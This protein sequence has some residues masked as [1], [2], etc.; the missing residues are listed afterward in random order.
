MT[1]WSHGRP[2]FGRMKSTMQKRRAEVGTLLL[3]F[4]VCARKTVLSKPPHPSPAQ[5]WASLDPLL[6]PA[7][8][9]AGFQLGE[10]GWIP[11]SVLPV[12]LDCLCGVSFHSHVPR[13]PRGTGFAARLILKSRAWGRWGMEGENSS[14]SHCPQVPSAALVHKA[15]D[16]KKKKKVILLAHGKQI[17]VVFGPRLGGRI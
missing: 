12:S 13:A 14:V 16:V 7:A 8:P 17:R 9:R 6:Q 3:S 15:G 4:L 5:P 11:R 10:S 2:P 1:L